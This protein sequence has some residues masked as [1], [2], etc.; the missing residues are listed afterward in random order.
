MMAPVQL[1][2]S[3]Q[4][5]R[6]PGKNRPAAFAFYDPGP[7]LRGFT[8][9]INP[10]AKPSASISPPLDPCAE[11]FAKPMSSEPAP[12]HRP[13]IGTL[14]ATPAHHALRYHADS[15]A[16]LCQQDFLRKLKVRSCRMRFASAK[17]TLEQQNACAEAHSRGCYRS[18]KFV[19]VVPG[20][21]WR[22]IFSEKTSCQQK[23]KKGER[24]NGFGQQSK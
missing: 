14:G 8:K 3:C 12:S 5:I 10:K 23:A 13:W 11:G 7:P 18:T 16:N 6:M 4:A 24:K 17:T 2:A 20:A 15:K 9:N 1:S 22:N 19:I 21:S